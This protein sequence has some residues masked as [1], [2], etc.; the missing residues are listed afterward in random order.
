MRFTFCLLMLWGTSARAAELPDTSRMNVLFINIEDCNAG[1]FGCYGNAI[2]RTP[3]IDR[4]ARSA[5]LFDSA[6]CQGISCNPSRSSFLTGLRPTTT[7]V[8][9]NS[10]VM[11]DLLPTGTLTLPEVV[12]AGGFTTAN[13]GKLFH[14]LEYA[15]RPMLAFD[16]L[17]MHDKPE[18]WKGPGPILN[19]PPKRPGWEKAPAD[20]KSPEFR[21]WKRKHSDRYGDSGL[22]REEEYDYRMAATAAALLRDF[23]KQPAGQRFFLSVSQSKP[24]T[25]LIS[26]KKYV[27]IYDP[28]KIPPPA[29]PVDSLVNFPAHSLKRARGG[30]PD[31]FRDAQPS[32][33]QAREAIAAY[34]A[35]VTFVDENVGMM[36]DALEETGLDRNTIVIFFGDH[37]FHLG[38]H[39]FWSKYSMLEAT[40]RVPLIVRVPGAPANGQVCRQFIELVDLFPTIGELAGLAVPANLEGTSFAPLLGDANRTWK[41]AVFMSGGPA[42]RGHSVRNRRYSYLEYEGNRP[43]AALFDLERD[44]WETRNLVDDP[45]LADV[46]NEMAALLKAGWRGALPPAQ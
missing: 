28:T 20:Q 4:F 16:R 5:V 27:D 33:Q 44:P 46:R 21:E 9:S 7:N 39:G 34:Y 12:K 29:A 23:A 25:P 1:V 43:G 30:N 14:R 36:L 37:G 18:G 22:N 31:L 24:H 38:D 19:F 11:D 8:Y 6:Y 45:Q 15:D 17:E 35:C 3:N 13:V 2:C 32:L 41:R 42:D 26:P 10:D 40:R